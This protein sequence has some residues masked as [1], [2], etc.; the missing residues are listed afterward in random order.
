VNRS[1]CSKLC[2]ITFVACTML[3]GYSDALREGVASGLS[4]GVSQVIQSMITDTGEAA[5]GGS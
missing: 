5:L 2:S 1:K 3:I 4:S